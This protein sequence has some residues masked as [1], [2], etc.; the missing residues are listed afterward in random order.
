MF[1]V[2]GGFVE[3]F[4]EFAKVCVEFSKAMRID[5]LVVL[6]PRVEVSVLDVSLL[7]YNIVVVGGGQCKQYS[8]G[9]LHVAFTTKDP[10][11]GNDVGI[12]GGDG[13][14]PSA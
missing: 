14:F 7:N 5:D 9:A 8:K 6:H 1:A 3:G 13:E 2:L 11:A 4:R 12:I 10:S